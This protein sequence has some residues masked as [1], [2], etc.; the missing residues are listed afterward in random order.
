[1][2]TKPNDPAQQGLTPDGLAS[3]LFDL[4]LKTS[5]PLKMRD[6]REAAQQVIGFLTESLF[7]AISS[8]KNDVIVFLMDSLIYVVSMQAPD[9]NARKEMLKKIGDTIANAGPSLTANNPVPAAAK[10]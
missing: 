6:P 9:D 10:P 5:D 1:M 3:Q 2:M 8:S 7:Y 4:A